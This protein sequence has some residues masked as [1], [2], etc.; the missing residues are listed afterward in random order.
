MLT[1][2]VYFLIISIPVIISACQG[3]Q[4]K[5]SANYFFKDYYY[6]IDE[7]RS[8]KV[9]VYTP[10]NNDSLESFFWYFINNGGYLTRTE[11]NYKLQITQI[12]TEDVLRN[13]TSLHRFRLC[14]YFPENP[15]ICQ[16][17]D[18]NIES[19]AVFPFEMIDSSSVFLYKIAWNELTDTTIENSI[20]RNRHFMGYEKLNWKG[21]VYDGV[22]FGIREEI[23][24]GSEALGYQTFK[25]FTE[26]YYAKGI[27]LIR[28]SK[29]VQNVIKMEYELAD[30]T[31]MKTLENLFNERTQTQ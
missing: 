22:K 10:I 16:P 30:T 8:G 2:I 5:P 27:G 7:L 4:E 26:E 1:R 24:V 3:E 19:S 20:I 14:E 12:V 17:I 25:A 6:P 11:Y 29:N 21:K 23:S 31:N 9:Y 13:G 18:V 15:D 28:Y